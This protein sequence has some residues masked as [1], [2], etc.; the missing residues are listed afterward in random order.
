MLLLDTGPN[1]EQQQEKMAA[2]IDVPTKIQNSLKS[3]PIEQKERNHAL[4]ELT[5]QRYELFTKSI[6]PVTLLYDTQKLQNAILPMIMGKWMINEPTAR[7]FLT[8]APSEKSTQDLLEKYNPLVSCDPR[9]KDLYVLEMDN[10]RN[11]LTTIINLEKNKEKAPS[12]LLW[13]PPSMHPKDPTAQRERRLDLLHQVHKKSLADN[14]NMH[15]IRHKFAQIVYGLNFGNYSVQNKQ[16]IL[17]TYL[18]QFNNST[19]FKESYWEARWLCYNYRQEGKYTLMRVSFLE[20]FSM[21]NCPMHQIYLLKRKFQ[22]EHKI[23]HSPQW[24]LSKIS[25][26]L[27]P[28]KQYHHFLGSSKK[29]NH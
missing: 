11:A 7:Q 23:Q 20:N 22:H 25:S 15:V 10:I 26:P 6:N 4:F 27:L 28:Q 2:L 5:D 17:L 3:L 19:L 1:P 13:S 16:E 12:A 29:T 24:R 18:S 9:S 14:F 8:D 21:E